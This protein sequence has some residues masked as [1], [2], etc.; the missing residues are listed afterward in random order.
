MQIR[1]SAEVGLRANHGHRLLRH[2]RSACHGA[3]DRDS[4]WPEGGATP[5]R[6][7]RQCQRLKGLAPGQMLVNGVVCSTI[8]EATTRGIL[9]NLRG[10]S[11]FARRHGRM[12]ATVEE[13]QEG[14]SLP[15]DVAGVEITDPDLRALT[16]G[17]CPNRILPSAGAHRPLMRCRR[18]ARRITQG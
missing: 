4:G 14:M 12:A 6:R 8:E 2:L 1:Y 10:T 18:R 3:H 13:L 16:L 17:R 7:A 9:D 11:N 15:D 5:L